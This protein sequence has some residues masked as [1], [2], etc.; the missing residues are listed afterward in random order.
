VTARLGLS[1]GY[2]RIRKYNILKWFELSF[3]PSFHGFLNAHRTFKP[4]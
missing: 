3:I 2:F 1:G 4:C